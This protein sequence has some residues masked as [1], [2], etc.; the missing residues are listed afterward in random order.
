MAKVTKIFDKQKM[1]FSAKNKISVKTPNGEQLVEKVWFNGFVCVYE[2]SFLSIDTQEFYTIKCTENHQ[3]LSLDHG[4]VMAKDLVSGYRFQN[5]YTFHSSKKLR[6]KY[7]TFDIEVPDE[8]CYIL[9]SGIISHNSSSAVCGSVSQGIEPIYKN[10]YIQNTASG[11][12]NRINPSLLNLMKEKNVYS[13][14]V[15][16]DI[17]KN[18]GS[19]QH[20][21][22]LTD[23]EKLVFK[24]AF[25]IDQKIII[26]LASNRQRYVDQSQSV[27]LF[28]SA[29]EDEEYISE[30]H[31]LA[32]KDPFVKS[33]Y[34]IRSTNGV[35]V[36]KS[37]CL[38][39]HG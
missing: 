16:S 28:F 21:D 13:D 36:S 31:K 35:T 3:F 32:F 18:N 22:W 39:C 12:V 25:E 2:L 37:E 1:W 29:E 11:K 9:E 27:N 15:V 23:D 33:L 34:Y 24:T 4:W 6:D 26:R 7:P 17:I 20:V 38:S 19:V 5:N 14:E 30:V 8:H 10:A